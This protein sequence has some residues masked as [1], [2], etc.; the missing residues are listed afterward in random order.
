VDN[1]IHRLVGV[2]NFALQNLMRVRAIELGT[3]YTCVAW[4]KIVSQSQP[5]RRQGSPN[6]V[7]PQ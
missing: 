4:R 5:V 6:P 2:V 7:T 3:T 1:D